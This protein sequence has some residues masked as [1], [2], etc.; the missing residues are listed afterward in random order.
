M[1]LSIPA[2]LAVCLFTAVA[3]QSATVRGPQGQS[4]TANAPVWMTIHRGESSPL[5]IGID[6]TKF[7]GPVTVS[8][9]Q[10]PKGVE[11]DKASIKAET[12]SVTFILKASK[13][14]DLVSNQ[15]VGITVEDP[16]GRQATQFVNLTVND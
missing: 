6:R 5:E 2:A 9:F 1:R 8:I 13:T 12:T 16:S 3:C 15:A 7:T 11:S 4:V 10:L 14:A